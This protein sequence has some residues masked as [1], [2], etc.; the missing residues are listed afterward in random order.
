MD[1]EVSGVS[2]EDTP[3]G[4]DGTNERPDSDQAG[5]RGED[6]AGRLGESVEALFGTVFREASSMVDRFAGGAGGGG[7]D[8]LHVVR[9][10]ERPAELLDAVEGWVSDFFR[11]ASF[12]RAA[13][14][15]A[16]PRS[17]RG[18]SRQPD[19]W[20]EATTDAGPGGAG[21]ECRYCPFCQTLAAVRGSRPELYEQIGDTAR[22][23]IDLVRQAAEQPRGTR[24]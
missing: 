2:D 3:G 19:V 21:A 20:A 1:A 13:A 24:H 7:R 9:D 18:P 23:L 6:Y 14:G 10:G 11:A 12:G 15:F 16:W 17:G 5:E 22:R 4:T 8:R